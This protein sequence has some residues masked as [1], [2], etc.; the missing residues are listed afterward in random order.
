M[1]Y[2]YGLGWGYLEQDPASLRKFGQWVLHERSMMLPSYEG[3]TKSHEQ[4]LLHTNWEQQTMESTVVDG[5]SCCVNLQC[6]WLGI[7]S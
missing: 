4:K 3:R 7:G 6:R 1:R 2:L 5:T